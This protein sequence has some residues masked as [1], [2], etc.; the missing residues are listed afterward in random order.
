VDPATVQVLSTT[1]PGFD[2]AARRVVATMRFRPARRNGYLVPV[3]VVIP[4]SFVPLGRPTPE[5]DLRPVP[6]RP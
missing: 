5:D 3:W 6:T 2:A 4:V 1:Y